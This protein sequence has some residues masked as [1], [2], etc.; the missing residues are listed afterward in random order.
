MVFFQQ[1]EIPHRKVYVLQRGWMPEECGGRGCRQLGGDEAGEISIRKS[2]F[3]PA[4]STRPG[5]ERKQRERPHT[6]DC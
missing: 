6:E 5:Q 2:I 1:P 4:N 3:W